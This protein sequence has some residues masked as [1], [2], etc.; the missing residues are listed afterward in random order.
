MGRTLRRVRLDGLMT[1]RAVVG[2][3]A[4]AVL[5]AAAAGAGLWWRHTEQEKKL[6]SAARAEVAAFATAWSGR[7]FSKPA[8]A[9]T[10]IT[11]DIVQADFAKATG[12]LGSGPVKVTTDGVSRTGD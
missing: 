8:I 12:G 2:G 1:N 3:V 11:S 10:G 9:F 5:V 6:D 7:S 4:G